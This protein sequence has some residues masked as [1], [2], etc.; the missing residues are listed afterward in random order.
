MNQKLKTDEIPAVADAMRENAAA[1]AA[2]RR[3]HKDL[4]PE[5]DAALAYAVRGLT[6]DAKLATCRYEERR[7]EEL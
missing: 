3:E 5:E 1:L 2:M 6:A 4:T 7:R